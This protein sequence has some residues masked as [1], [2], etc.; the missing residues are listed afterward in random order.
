MDRLS[1]YEVWCG[2]SGSGGR[3]AVS[4]GVKGPSQETAEEANRYAGIATMI[5][6]IFALNESG[7]MRP[8][9]SSDGVSVSDELT[10]SSE[11]M[12]CEDGTT[13]RRGLLGWE[14][15][16][17]S[18]GEPAMVSEGTV[19]I[20]IYFARGKSEAFFVAPESKAVG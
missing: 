15:K 3:L 5:S 18:S 12:C 10:R 20:V 1:E 9:R 8:P 16:G 11:R 13:P 17:C 4:R 7:K 2:D 14:S 6:I 19:W